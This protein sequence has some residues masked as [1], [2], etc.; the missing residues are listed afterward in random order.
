MKQK[1]ILKIVI[2][3]GLFDFAQILYRE[4]FKRMTPKVL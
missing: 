3:C 2:G 4:K 1:K